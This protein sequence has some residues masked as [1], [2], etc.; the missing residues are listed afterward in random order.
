L[1]MEK[2]VGRLKKG[3]KAD[4]V[5]FDGVS[6][7]MLAVA[8]EDPV[9]AVVLHSSPRDIDMVLVD[10]AVRKEGGRLVDVEVEAAPGRSEGVMEVG[11]VVT[12]KDVTQMVV[13][14]RRA[15]K[16]KTDRIDMKQG[17]E[18]VMDLFRMNRKGMLEGQKT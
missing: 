10:G 1:G 6:P 15:L 18:Y 4:L 16:E 8:E 17:E 12:W 2:E 9:A 14:S 3:M 11:K 5:V 13:K 7:A